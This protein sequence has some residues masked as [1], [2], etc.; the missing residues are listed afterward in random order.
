MRKLIILCT[1]LMMIALMPAAMAVP[2]V[3][4][5]RVLNE[6]SDDWAFGQTQGTGYDPNGPS[7]GDRLVMYQNNPPF[8][9]DID[10]LHDAG[11]GFNENL[12]TVGPGE[13]GYDIKAVYARLDSGT[14]YGLCE[15]YGNPTDLDGNGLIDTD[16]MMQDTA[17]TTGPNGQTG[18]GNTEYWEVRVVQGATESRLWLQNN[19]WT[20]A[21][22]GGATLT[23][24][25]VFTFYTG[26][27]SN[28]VYEISIANLD[29]RGFNLMPGDEFELTLV[30]GAVGDVHPTGGVLG[31]DIATV[32]L[33]IPDPKIDIEKYVQDRDG[34][35]LDADSPR[36]PRLLNGTIA[37]WKYVV[38]NTGDEPL[39]N[40]AVDDDIVGS[41]NCPKTI[42]NVSESMTCFESGSI[43]DDCPDYKNWATVEGF[44]VVSGTRVTDE[45][46]AHYY[47][48]E[49]PALTPTGLLG[50]I[51]VLG[52]IGIVGVKRRD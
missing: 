42:L 11:T 1:A 20:V 31:E 33:Q 37:Y 43:P 15:V 47:C 45:D 3:D 32:Y 34:K 38:T 17:G 8:W 21:N 19:V 4:G 49:I 50:L 46:P 16:P 5:Y 7:F 26:D 23:S 18:I 10:P 29:A 22:F 27:Q 40:I 48:E 24:G 52:M 51:G 2:V 6:W 39:E 14:I 44:G 9:F 12:A 36:G 41:I 35:W 25:D 28:S 13:S 30:A